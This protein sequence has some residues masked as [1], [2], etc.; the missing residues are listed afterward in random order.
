MA[1]VEAYRCDAEIVMQGSV[2]CVMQEVRADCHSSSSQPQIEWIFPIWPGILEMVT[3]DG[4]VSLNKA[5]ANKL[6][7]KTQLFW[8][9]SVFLG[10]TEIHDQSRGTDTL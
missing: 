9:F 2:T 4:G 5:V 7:K 1:Y 3:G 8:F 10:S 6:L